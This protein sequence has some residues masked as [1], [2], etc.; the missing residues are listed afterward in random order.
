MRCWPMYVSAAILLLTPLILAGCSGETTTGEGN[1]EVG[2]Q[3]YV[4]GDGTLT[5]LPPEERQPAP[6]LTG[7]TLTGDTFTLADHKGDVILL[8]VWASWCAPCRAEAPALWTVWDDT[9]DQNVQ[10]VG[11]VSRDSEASARAFA[12]RFDL[13]YPHL[14]DDNGS[15]QLLFRDTLPPQ[16]IPS[17]LVIDQDG[18]VAGRAL[19][20]VSESTLRGFI[21]PLLA[22]E[23]AADSGEA[24]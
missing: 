2:T 16:A 4:E 10:F 8:N 23:S 13:G 12:E 15:L 11:L 6:A 3:G 20:E 14:M 9:K 18:R 7:D 5:L 21:E 17:T 24:S 22:E 19:G 1:A